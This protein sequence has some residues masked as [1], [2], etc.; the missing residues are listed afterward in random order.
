MARKESPVNT[1]ARRRFT[2]STMERNSGRRETRLKTKKH[3][4]VMVMP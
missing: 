2:G 3:R 4:R 1:K